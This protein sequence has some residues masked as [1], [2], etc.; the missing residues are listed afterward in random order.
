MARIYQN[1]RMTDKVNE[2]SISS[3]NLFY[4]GFRDPLE[5][6]N[7][8]LNKFIDFNS[9]KASEI[10]EEIKVKGNAISEINRLWGIIMAKTLPKTDPQSTD[11]TSDLMKENKNELSEIDRIIKIDVGDKDG[12]AKITNKSLDKTLGMAVSY[13]AL[14]SFNAT[15]SA[16]C[17]KIQVQLDTLEQDF[18]NTMISISSTKEEIRNNRL[19]IE[20]I[21]RR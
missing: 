10:A 11:T 18:K 3:N 6:A 2:V 13:A 8:I 4:D 7:S 20:E 19:K 16:Y 9:Q 21:S 5:I 12:I 1:E 15:M 14:E 17:D